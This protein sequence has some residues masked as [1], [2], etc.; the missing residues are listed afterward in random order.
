MKN[1]KPNE[2]Q[3]VQKRQNYKHVALFDSFGNAI[4]KFNTNAID[5][6]VRLT[7]IL[8]R[9]N[10]EGLPDGTYIFKGKNS[11]SRNVYCDDYTV[12]KGKEQTLSE[13][14]P[15]LMAAQNFSPDVLSYDSALKMQVENEHL[16]IENSNLLQKIE[17]LEFQLSENETLSEDAAPNLF[18]SGKSFLTEIVTMAAP[19]LDKHFELKEKQLS[20]QAMA[21]HNKMNT[22][23]PSPE[24]AAQQKAQEHIYRVE[25]VE[26]WINGFQEDEETYNKLATFYNNAKSQNDFIESLQSEPELFND[27]QKNAL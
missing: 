13:A 15:V 24:Q 19:L 25:A 9:L 21:M 2:L 23:R 11:P 12:L 20:L 6:Q 18:E 3:A 1:Y 14:A 26:N 4:V 22:R 8:T 27:F 5:P 16:K 10:S 7:E 17:D